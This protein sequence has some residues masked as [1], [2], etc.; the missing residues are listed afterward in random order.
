MWKSSECFWGGWGY[1]DVTRNSVIAKV[2]G[3]VE[4][5]FSLYVLILNEKY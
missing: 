5:S 1:L 3:V 2:A 4:S